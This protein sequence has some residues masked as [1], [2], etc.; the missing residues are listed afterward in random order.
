MIGKLH[1]KKKPLTE[2]EPVSTRI[3]KKKVH[4]NV[5]KIGFSDGMV[6]MSKFLWNGKHV[7]ISQ[8]IL[9]MGTI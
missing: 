4:Q 6:P 3:E 1:C 2:I 8:V 9:T 5:H 7:L